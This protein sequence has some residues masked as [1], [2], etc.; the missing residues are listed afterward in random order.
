MTRFAACACIAIRRFNLLQIAALRCCVQFIH[1]CQKFVLFGFEVRRVLPN[2]WQRIAIALWVILEIFERYFGFFGKLRRLRLEFFLRHKLRR[3]L[4]TLPMPE[5][6]RHK[7]FKCSGA[8][9]RNVA[10]CRPLPRHLHP[11]RRPSR[12][13]RSKSAKH[14]WLKS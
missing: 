14:K 5:K 13:T 6:S 11:L 8:V 2:R 7:R 10:F 9:L 3:L 12:H 1:R 4:T